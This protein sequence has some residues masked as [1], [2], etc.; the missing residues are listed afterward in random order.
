MYK[1]WDCHAY[2][3]DCKALWAKIRARE[4]SERIKNDTDTP[5]FNLGTRLSS[6][7]S[8]EERNALF[9]SLEKYFVGRFP[10]G[11]QEVQA[12]GAVEK[13]KSR[14]RPDRG[15]YED[16]DLH[17]LNITS[18][19]KV[20]WQEINRIDDRATYELFLETLTDIGQTCTQGDSHRL[21]IVLSS[22]L[23]LA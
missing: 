4:I 3:A 10:N 19:L 9:E 14:Y 15:G 23:D 6:K 11:F 7:V 12:W 13:M 5:P 18:L 20:V 21:L 22:L 16:G 17:N 8:E 2:T 1:G